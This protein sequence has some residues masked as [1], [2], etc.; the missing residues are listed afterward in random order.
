MSNST[1]PGTTSDQPSPARKVRWSRRGLSLRALLI[2]LAGVAVGLGAWANHLRQVRAAAALIR[3][4][5][6]MY[7]FDFEYDPKTYTYPAQPTS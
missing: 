5:G 3:Q 1:E 2:L 6:G 4:H 7:Y